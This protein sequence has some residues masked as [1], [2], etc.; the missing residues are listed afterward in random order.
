MDAHG[1]GRRS[2]RQRSRS[3][4]SIAR[5]EP[6]R[7]RRERARPAGVEGA[8]RV[9]GE[10]EVEDQRP[11]RRRRRRGRRSSPCR[12]GSGRRRTSRCRSWRR[13]RAGTGRRHSRASR[14]RRATPRRRGVAATRARRSGRPACPRRCSGGRSRGRRRTTG[15]P[16][17]GS[18]LDLEA[19]AGI[20]WPVAWRGTRRGPPGGTGD[21]GWLRNRCS[22]SAH[23][24]SQA[25]SGSVP[26]RCCGPRRTA[27]RRAGASRRP[28]AIAGLGVVRVLG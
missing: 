27:P 15:R 25:A 17:A 28:D 13:G 12:A 3:P 26:S 4:A 11:G 8:R 23:Q 10:V 16:G 20:V 18:T 14:T 5:V 19:E 21:W 1:T 6:V 9:E 7:R 24:G 22:R 2:G